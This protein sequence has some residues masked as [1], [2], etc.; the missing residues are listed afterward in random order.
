MNR[1]IAAATLFLMPGLCNP[2]A[3]S[4]ATPDGRVWIQRSNT[5]TQKVLYLEMKYAPEEGTRNG[6][7]QFDT[8]VSVPTLANM[9]AENKEAALLAEEFE[10]QIKREKDPN[11][12]ED[13]QILVH[14]ERLSIRT[15][16]YTENHRVRFRNPTSWVFSGLKMLLDDQMPPERRQAAVVRL[17]KYAGLVPG[18]R[19]LATAM[20]ERTESK[21]PSLA[22]STHHAA[23]WK[24]SWREMRPL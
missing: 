12:A 24:H 5:F 20:M 2:Q 10:A 8:D 15:D 4:T 14:N 1:R 7:D 22:W 18:Y 9:F 23:N 3:V 19:P 17:K 16:N 21:W 13:L 11:V 6:L